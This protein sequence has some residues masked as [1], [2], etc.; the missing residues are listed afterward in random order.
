VLKALYD[1]ISTFLFISVR[2][3]QK[4]G[5]GPKDME[6]VKFHPTPAI[7]ITTYYNKNKQPKVTNT[8]QPM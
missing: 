1:L 8:I 4:R 7:H 6:H 3:I 2:K 5:R